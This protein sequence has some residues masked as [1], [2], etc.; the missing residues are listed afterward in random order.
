MV[1]LQTS[2]PGLVQPKPNS[3]FKDFFFCIFAVKG[4]HRIWLSVFMKRHE[5]GWKAVSAQLQRNAM[6]LVQELKDLKTLAVWLNAHDISFDS[7]WDVL[8]VSSSTECPVYYSY[9]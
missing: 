2:Q 9:I 3:C 4:Q 8:P 6:F 7:V 5:P 1:N